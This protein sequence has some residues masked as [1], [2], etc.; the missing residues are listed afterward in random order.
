MS[1]TREYVEKIQ[2]ETV[3]VY[4][5]LLSNRM[6]Y[7]GITNNIERRYKEHTTKRQSWASK[8]G[9]IKI[10]YS[11]EFN[12]RKEARIREVA[13]KRFGV[14]KFVLYLEVHKRSVFD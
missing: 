12:T 14:S 5:L 9:V 2:K 11:I 10:V 6:H 4:I 7:C 13:I 1:S 8:K 3:H